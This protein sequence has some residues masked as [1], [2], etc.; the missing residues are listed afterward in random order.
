MATAVPT[1]SQMQAILKAETR[2]S[3]DAHP[4]KVYLYK[5]LDRRGNAKNVALS[6]ATY[7]PTPKGLL[8]TVSLRFDYQYTPL[9]YTNVSIKHHGRFYVAAAPF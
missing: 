4:C 7:D 1:P 5:T 2:R 8:S 9:Q 6:I 3:Q